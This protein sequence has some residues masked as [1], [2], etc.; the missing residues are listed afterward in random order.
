MAEDE[1]EE[2]FPLPP[3]V[4]VQALGERIPGSG[5]GQRGPRAR[6]PDDRGE[7]ESNGR[8]DRET[9][10]DALHRDRDVEPQLTALN[11]FGPRPVSYTHLR[12]HETVLDLVCRLLLEKKTH[13]NTTYHSQLQA[14]NKH[15]HITQ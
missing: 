2:L 3:A 4:P 7:G 1:D 15:H 10:E 14:H 8:T 13:T 11:E 6:E 5:G 9:D 12:A